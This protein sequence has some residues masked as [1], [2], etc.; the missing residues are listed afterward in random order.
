MKRLPYRIRPLAEQDLEDHTRYLAEE[1]LAVALRFSDAVVDA[2][3]T[4]REHPQIGASRQMKSPRLAG[5][6]IWPV[7][8]FERWL[9]FYVPTDTVVHIVRVLHGARDVTTLLE[10]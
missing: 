2:I 6:R 4:L 8:R 10:D 1:D 5:L 7:P 3:T 9:I